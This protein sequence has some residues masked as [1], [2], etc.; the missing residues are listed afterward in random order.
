MREITLEML[1]NRDACY[2][3]QKLFRELF[4][5]RVEV[6]PELC[7][8]HAKDFEWRWACEELLSGEAQRDCRKKIDDIREWESKRY[9]EIHSDGGCGDACYAVGDEANAKMAKA[10]G[11]SFVKVEENG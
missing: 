9:D 10:F 11:E 1:E 2:G 5:D 7:V 8:K 6:T 3:Q 4:G